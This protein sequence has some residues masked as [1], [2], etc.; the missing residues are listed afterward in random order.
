MNCE[1]LCLSGFAYMFKETV[2]LK[3][4]LKNNR[5]IEKRRKIVKM[6]GKYGD[7]IL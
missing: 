3:D 6:S 1:C 7:D 4:R 2:K 5:E